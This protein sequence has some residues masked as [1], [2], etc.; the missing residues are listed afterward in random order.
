MQQHR[1][2]NIDH[3]EG[4]QFAIC[5][6]GWTGKLNDF[7]EHRDT[8]TEPPTNPVQQNVS[9]PFLIG[10]CHACNRSVQFEEEGS[11]GKCENCGKEYTY[12]FEI[13]EEL[14]T[15]ETE[16]WIVPKAS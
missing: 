8:E 12:D 16:Y 10:R 3:F 7:Q 15:A 6:C 5:E 13:H 11:D 14:T 2:E 1:I 4:H 9:L